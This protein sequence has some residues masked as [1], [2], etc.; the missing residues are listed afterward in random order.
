MDGSKPQALLWDAHF[1]VIRLEG[2]GSAGFLHGQTS[3]RVDGA[4]LGQLL[5]ACW[6]NATGRVQALL[7]LRLDDQ[8]ADVLVLNG[9]S[10]HLAKGLDRVIFPADRVRLGPARQ[11]RRLQHLS[12]DQAPGPET[13]LWLDDAAVPPPPWDRTQ[14]CAAADLERWRLRQGWPLGAEEINGD[15]NPFELG[16]AG[17][18]NLEKGCYLG[19]ETLAKLGSRGAVKQQLRSWQC[20]DPVA[21]ELKPGDGLTLNGERAGRITSVA[22]PNACEPQCGLALIRRQALEAEELQSETTESRPHPLTLTLQRPGA[23]QDPPSGR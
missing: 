3:A 12:S 18:V 6:L 5:Q 10:D 13:V 19:Q 7:E 16:L 15:T 20:A 11:Q 8:G 9:N 17:W 14:A 4:A 1:D 21:A 23:F 2:S 22:H